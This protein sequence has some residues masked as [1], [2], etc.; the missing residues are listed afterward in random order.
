VELGTIE[1]EIRIDASPEV[2]FDVVSKPEHV[3]EWWPDEATYDAVPG[4][5]GELVFGDRDADGK[6]ATITVL[7][8]LPPRLFRF[9]WTHPRDEAPT[10][11]NSLLVTLDLEP[12]DGGTLLRLTETG[13]RERG[14][15][16]AV[17][18]EQFHDHENGWAHF[19]PRLEA[20]A[21]KVAA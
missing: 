20:Y 13:F 12:A 4:S 16:V 17:L 5:T 2:V 14:W 1:R 15:E 3:R 18:E 11:A 7:E 19:L 21:A 6:V 8:V 9:R 10:E